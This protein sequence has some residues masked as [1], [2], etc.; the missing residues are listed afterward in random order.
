MIYDLELRSY[1]KNTNPI[2]LLDYLASSFKYKS[3]EEWIAAIAEGLVDIN[4]QTAVA[5][6]KIQKDDLVV[7][8][9]KNY[10]EPDI[11]A[12][13]N[14]LWENENIAVIE[15]PA[16]LPVSSGNRFYK[17][18]LINLVREGEDNPTISPIH[19]L[20]RETSGLIVFLKKQ[21]SERSIKENLSSILD[22]KVYLAIVEGNFKHDVYMLQ[23]KLENCEK[24]PIP[25][26]TVISEMG[27]DAATVFC[28]LASTKDYSL[29][30][31]KLLTGRK[32]QIRAHA[33]HLG[34]PIV[35][36]KL[37]GK[38]EGKYLL[39]R[40]ENDILTEVDYQELGARTHMLHAVHLEVLLP[41]EDRLSF[42]SKCWSD[43]FSN[44]LSLFAPWEE[45][46]QKFIESSEFTVCEKY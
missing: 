21:F 46:L 3:E 22:N 45:K 44:Y 39:K 9:V 4:G 2:K 19:R 12:W 41:S 34:Y 14:K 37:Y 32:H 18:N 13:Y 20:D 17:Q 8:T 1:A 5:G 42:D 25:Y 31:V 7:Y 35:G 43:E 33:A 15:K 10:E 26:K 27:K 38:T 24:P 30:A 36:D 23:T 6:D 28:K 40:K 11:E 16:D 29:L